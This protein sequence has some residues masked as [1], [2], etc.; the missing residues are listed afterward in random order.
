MKFNRLYPFSLKLLSSDTL[1][2]KIE[3]SGYSFAGK[4]FNIPIRAAAGRAV[5]YI[6]IDAGYCEIDNE[7]RCYV[8]KT[9]A[10]LLVTVSDK[11]GEAF[12]T[13][14]KLGEKR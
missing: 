11:G 8:S 6:D 12:E 7:S 5:I 3:K 10:A 1:A 4:S 9:A 14:L 2:V 13:T